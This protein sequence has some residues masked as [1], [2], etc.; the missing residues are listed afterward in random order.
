MRNAFFPELEYIFKHAVIQDV[1]YQSL[2]T[3]RRQELHGA[4]GRAIEELYADR[5]EE[6]AT[7][8]AYHYA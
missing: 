6:Q 3:Q 8:L 2:L 4:I 7:I 5:L 1:A